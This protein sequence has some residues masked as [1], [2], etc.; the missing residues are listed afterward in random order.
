MNPDSKTEKSKLGSETHRSQSDPQAR[1]FAK[2][3]EK[4]RMACPDNV[5]MVE[6]PTLTDGVSSHSSA[7]NYDGIKI[8][9]GGGGK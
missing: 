1:F 7:R 5:L 3:F 9:I 2:R 6:L 4:N 8:Y